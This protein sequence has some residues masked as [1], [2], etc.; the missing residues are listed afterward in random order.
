LRIG[1]EMASM[2]LKSEKDA[3]DLSRVDDPAIEDARLVAG[4]LLGHCGR[5]CAG[6]GSGPSCSN[7][8]AKSRQSIQPLQAGHRMKYSASSMTGLPTRS[9]L[10]RPRGMSGLVMPS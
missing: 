9:P 2:C 5:S 6:C 8:H 10:Y 3:L 1:S 7:T 4:C